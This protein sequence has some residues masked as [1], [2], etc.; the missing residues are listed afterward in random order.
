MDDMVPRPFAL[1]AAEQEAIAGVRRRIEVAGQ[2]DDA[3]RAA[4]AR[5]REEQERKDIK[6]ARA[7][8]RAAEAEELR[9]QRAH[10]WKALW[11]G[12]PALV[13]SLSFAIFGGLEAGEF[14]IGF[15]GCWLGFFSIA[16]AVADGVSDG[17]AALARREERHDRSIRIASNA[18][19]ISSAVDKLGEPETLSHY[20]VREGWELSPGQSRLPTPAHLYGKDTLL[21]IARRAASWGSELFVGIPAEP[22]PGRGDDK[23][24]K[25]AEKNVAGSSQVHSPQSSMSWGI[26][27]LVDGVQTA[28]GGPGEY[29]HVMPEPTGR[30]SSGDFDLES[31]DFNDKYRVTGSSGRNV[32]KVLTPNVMALLID[33][34]DY[35]EDAFTEEL[36][37]P[38][39]FY[40]VTGNQGYPLPT[41]RGIEIGSYVN[42]S[43]RFEYHVEPG[44]VLVFRNHE[45]DRP[46]NPI[47]TPRDEFIFLEAQFSRFFEALPVGIRGG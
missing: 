10:L 21:L 37:R 43:H 3:R 34:Y 30:D 9:K 1:T 26:L 47:W 38:D 4:E 16:E 36:A 28:P 46:N 32:Y 45:D 25:D 8:K 18:A 12:L 7:R 13:L 42:Y 40:L 22:D 15:L 33:T 44:S 2:A 20:L 11:S 17:M 39:E 14:W 19:L 24:D 27:A 23:G 31:Q 41:W 6:L 29:V 5:I 35:P